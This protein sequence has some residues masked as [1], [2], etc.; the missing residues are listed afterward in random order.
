MEYVDRFFQVAVDYAWGWPLVILLIGGGLYLTILSR[1]VPFLEIRHAFEILRGKYDNPDDPGEIT[2]LQA[3][4]TAIAATVGVG[5]IGGVAIAI[6]QGGPGAVFWM[7][8]AAL[9]G[10]GTKFFTCTLACMYR[11]VDETG[12]PQGGPMYTIEVGLGPKFRPLAIFFSC[13]GLVGSLCLLQANQLAEILQENHGVQREVSATLI[14][15]GVGAVV[16]GGIRRIARFSE[17]L[18]P[19]MCCLYVAAS[20]YVLATRAAVLPGVLWQIVS[21]AFTGSA[22]AGGALGTVIITG[23]K[24]AAFSN[25]AG[26]GT[27]PMAHGAA[28]TN[29]PVREGL[30][31]M[32][33]PLIDTIIVCTMTALVILSS[34]PEFLE[35]GEGG[36]LAGVSLTSRAFESAMGPTGMWVVT[37]SVTLFSVS[38]MFGYS[39]YGRK[40]LSYL[41]GQQ[42]GR[43]YNIV[44]VA[45]LAI[46]AIWSVGGV[47]NVLDTAFALMALPNMIATLILAPK[48]MQAARTYFNK[49]GVVTGQPSGR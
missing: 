15:L 32:L 38:T 7:W 25:E 1:F 29:E 17:M 22:I 44:Y 12:I 11:K 39:Y 47:I 37:I 43:Y 8:V 40:C 49:Y 18:V 9:V 34:G 4:T 21:D 35:A 19:A 36:T 45:T 14:A 46:G 2:H 13:C 5:N 10:M 26:I 42:R 48:V 3:L 33:G 30:V 27:A 28:K 24:R 6:T 20:L 31:A 23:V 41:I 16:L